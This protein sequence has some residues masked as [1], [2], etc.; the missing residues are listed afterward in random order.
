MAKLAIKGGTPI[1]TKPF[2][3]WPIY[4]ERE[5]EAVVDVVKSGKWWRGAYSAVELGAEK[6]SGRS[7][8]EEF[9][10]KFAKYHG[11]KYAVATSSGSGALDVAVKSIGVGPG[12]EVIVPPYTFV[13]TATCVLQNNAVPIFVDI[14][15]DTY[16]I[17]PDKIEDAITEKTKAIIPVHFAGNLANMERICEIAK[18]YNLKVIEDAAHAHGVEWKGKKM[19]GTFG[20]IGMFSFQQSKNMTAGEGGAIITNDEEL[21]KLCFSYH[22]YGRVEGRPWYEIHRLGWNYRMTELQAALLLVQLE[23]LDQLNFRRT[24]NANYLTQRLN[25]IEGIEPLRLDS[26]ITK[27]SY[28]LYIF[29]YNSKYFDGIH[30]DVFIKAMNKEG[31]PVTQGYTF[32]IYSNPLFINKN[33][34]PKRCPV[35]CKFYDK[36]IDYANFKER[37]PVAE[38]AC[39]EEAVWLTSNVL[40]G[41]KKDMDDIANAIEKIKENIQELRDIS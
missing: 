12:D 23:R 27:P 40:L 2:S 13:A 30:R 16:N 17:D 4:D 26:E 9:E 21:Y 39:Y 31:I 35:S 5:V 15:P 19:A 37:C 11:A 29:K 24:E 1:R 41:S 7:K 32:P 10:E 34:F 18:K 14:D 22:H 20:D 33:F 38:R 3:A 36:N 6:V 8:V 28:Y 25:Q